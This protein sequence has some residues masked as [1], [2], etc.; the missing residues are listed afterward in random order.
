MGDEQAVKEAAGVPRPHRI[1]VLDG[2]DPVEADLVESVNDLGPVDGPEARDAVAVPAGVPRVRPVNGKA[3][4]PGLVPRGRIDLDVLRLHVD[5]PLRP[6]ADGRDWID[7]EPDEVGRVVVQVEA[8]VKH[9]V[10]ELR[11]VAEVAGVAV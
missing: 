10:P 9:P 6:H 7:T 1:L 4:Y 3:E 2:D 8:E 11:R 5:D